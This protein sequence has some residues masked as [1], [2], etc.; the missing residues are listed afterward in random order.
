MLYVVTM[1]LSSATANSLLSGLCAADEAAGEPGVLPEADPVEV[2]QVDAQHVVLH[3]QV[4]LVADLRRDP[5]GGLPG[6]PGDEV[7]VLPGEAPPLG[8][9]CLELGVGLVEGVDEAQPGPALAVG[10]VAPALAHDVGG[11]GLVDEQDGLGVDEGQP[12]PEDVV[13]HLRG[14]VAQPRA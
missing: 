9:S 8:G 4:E 11:E 2:A 5:A 12:V 13:V 1:M 7:P 10:Q 6:D 14:A 3:P